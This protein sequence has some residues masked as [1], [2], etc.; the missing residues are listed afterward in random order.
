[1]ILFLLQMLFMNE[2]FLCNIHNAGHKHVSKI[3]VAEHDIPLLGYGHLEHFDDT[4]INNLVD[5]KSYRPPA[6]GFPN[7]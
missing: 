6:F 4:L 3:R 2:I 5:V 1:M 7:K